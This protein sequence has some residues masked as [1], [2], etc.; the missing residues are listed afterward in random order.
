[1]RRLVG[2]L[3]IVGLLLLVPQSGVSA[4]VG[5]HCQSGQGP[6]FGLEFASLRQQVGPPMGEPLECE[7][8]EPSSGDVVQRTTTG[9][10]VSSATTGMVIFTTSYDHWG[11]TP[12][13]IEHW[14]GWHTGLAP[15]S[16]VPMRAHEG[17]VDLPL[18]S[19]TYAVVEAATVI[20]ADAA[21]GR[22]IVSR[23]GT[24]YLVETSA[25]C[26]DTVPGAGQTVF[27]RSADGFA[28]A[29]ADLILAVGRRAC[30]IS[31]SHP[32]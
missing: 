8:T 32:L 30:S 25:E 12:S 14:T 15:P 29:G 26:L 24:L 13:G 4:Q 9:V 23:Q 1:M 18:A 5:P 28:A 7:H 16:M 11:L 2:P 10:A 20:G 3:A 6:Q 19:A 31:A 27:T 21:Q 17:D 22:L